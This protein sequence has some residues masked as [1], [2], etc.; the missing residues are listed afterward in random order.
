MTQFLHTLFMSHQELTANKPLCDKIKK[1]LS[2]KTFHIPWA[3]IQKT[4]YLKL[5]YSLLNSFFLKTITEHVSVTAMARQVT[6]KLSQNCSKGSPFVNSDPACVVSLAGLQSIQLLNNPVA[7]VRRTA[8][9][10]VLAA[11]AAPEAS[12]EPIRSDIV[13]N[14]ENHS[15]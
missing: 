14:K 6:S 5:C 15:P 8:S 3:C 12:H 13:I 7:M 4:G 11:T 1:N 9:P 10:N 2:L